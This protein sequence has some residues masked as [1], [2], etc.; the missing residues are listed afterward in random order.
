MDEA[1]GSVVDSSKVTGLRSGVIRFQTQMGPQC[2]LFIT[3]QNCPE[4]ILRFVGLATPGSPDG[5]T[6]ASCP[7]P[8][9][10]S[11]SSLAFLCINSPASKTPDVPVPCVPWPSLTPRNELAQEVLRCSACL[12][13]GPSPAASQLLAR[14]VICFGGPIR[15]PFFLPSDSLSEAT[16]IPAFVSVRTRPGSLVPMVALAATEAAVQEP[17]SAPPLPEPMEFVCIFC[18]P[19]I[20]SLAGGQTPAP[21]VSTF[22]V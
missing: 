2:V 8:A 12:L 16:D 10:R 17:C 1:A 9:G 18:S 6:V 22:A 21:A 7:A 3:V 11:C 14:I 15:R 13:L 4:H 5:A 20:C 19:Q